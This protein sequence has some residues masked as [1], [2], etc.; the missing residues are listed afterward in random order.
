MLCQRRETLR[1]HMKE[2][3]L[4]KYLVISSLLASCLTLSLP[5]TAS[6]TT[7]GKAATE[8]N[9]DTVV[10]TVNGTEITLGH[11]I[12]ARQALP[13]QYN[14]Y[15]PEMLFS[16]LLD[17]LVQQT[18]LAQSASGT[19]SRR[20]K[21]ALENQRRALMA[22]DVIET[23]MAR[24]PSEKDVQQFF[25]AE[26]NSSGSSIEYNAS[27]ILVET[28]EA[29]QTLF[30]LLKDGADFAKLAVEKSSGPSGP[31]GGQLGWFGAG[32]MVPPFENAV[33]A[34]T[35]GE[36]S[37]P[38]QT[39][40]GWHVIKLNDSREIAPP[41]LVEVREEIES[42]LRQKAAEMHIQALVAAAE[43]TR[44]ATSEIDS[45]LLLKNALLD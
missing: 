13:E 18:V 5:A 2:E 19:E 43:I 17:Q 1:L 32:M 44:M 15:P 3:T 24:D 41:T 42:K 22:G 40:F 7:T 38:V 30:I 11:L 14:N 33:Q 34:M 28:E 4:I 35:V 36:I 39:Q 12:L 27:H 8:A 26:F 10:A 20:I 16:G 23:V 31:N 37:A 9:G 6:D 45:A 25:D 21:L 29:A